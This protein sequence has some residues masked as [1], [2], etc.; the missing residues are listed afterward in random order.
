MLA[1]QYATSAGIYLTSQV[2]PT[3]AV[4]KLPYADPSNSNSTH[5]RN[6]DGANPDHVTQYHKL[7]E[8][9]YYQLS[10]SLL[11]LSNMGQVSIK[12]HHT[13]RCTQSKSPANQFYQGC[14]QAKLD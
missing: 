14:N 5:N 2:K 6:I 9:M 12:S 4:L 11:Y 8:I 1:K 3:E 13:V 7:L 10:C